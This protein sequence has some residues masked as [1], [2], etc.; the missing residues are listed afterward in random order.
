[1]TQA[2]QLAKKHRSGAVLDPKTGLLQFELRD[3]RTAKFQASSTQHRRWSLDAQPDDKMKQNHQPPAPSFFWDAVDEPPIAVLP[4]LRP[5]LELTSEADNLSSFTP[6]LAYYSS[7]ESDSASSHYS[8]RRDQPRPGFFRSC[9]LGCRGGIRAIRGFK[10]PKK[11]GSGE[12]RYPLRDGKIQVFGDFPVRAGNS[13]FDNCATR[14]L[15]RMPHK[16]DPPEPLNVMEPLKKK[17][18]YLERSRKLDREEALE[19][20]KRRRQRS[21][22]Y[23]F[24]EAQ[25]RYPLQDHM[26]QVFYC[27]TEL[28]LEPNHRRSSFDDAS[29][30]KYSMRR[31]YA[32]EEDIRL[33][34]ARKTSRIGRWL[35]SGTDK[36]SKSRV[37]LLTE[38]LAIGC[39]VPFVCL[40]QPLFGLCFCCSTESSEE[41]DD[42]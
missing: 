41:E 40:A 20:Q 28:I 38:F 4:R 37:R 1:M 10:K 17:D 22:Y 3:G 31:P 30:Y 18:H 21:P 36:R 2:R 14:Q 16:I 34:E 7:N 33:P 32:F 26:T 25:W 5:S 23:L 11:V 42:F 9:F 24:P 35:S 13:S 29:I 8:Q 12:W 6:N 39:C 27:N 19:T 15:P